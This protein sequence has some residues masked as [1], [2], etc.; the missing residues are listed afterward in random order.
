MDIYIIYT[1][2]T[3]VYVSLS[4][5]KTE[6]ARPFLCSLFSYQKSFC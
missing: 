3:C 2:H 4:F 1:T 5:T 6:C